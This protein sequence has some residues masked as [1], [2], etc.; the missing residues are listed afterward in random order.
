M[1]RVKGVK[2]ARHIL[3]TVKKL[4][5]KVSKMGANGWKCVRAEGRLNK[6]VPSNVQGSGAC[7]N[8]PPLTSFGKT[9]SRISSTHRY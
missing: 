2:A 9:I 6:G 7:P 1:S 3:Y 5:D 8:Q 4:G